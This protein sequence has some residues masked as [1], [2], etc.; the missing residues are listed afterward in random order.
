[1][2]RE[3]ARRSRCGSICVG[4]CLIESL[5]KGE[6]WACE[7]AA[8]QIQNPLFYDIYVTSKL[9]SVGL[10]SILGSAVAST[11]N[12]RQGWWQGRGRLIL[13]LSPGIY[14][15][16]ADVSVWQW[17]RW[18][19][20]GLWKQRRALWLLD[21]T[22]YFVDLGFIWFYMIYITFYHVPP[23]KLDS[24]PCW[25]MVI[26]PLIGIAVNVAIIRNS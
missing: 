4:S 10:W 15:W 5:P 3:S 20:L 7:V 25:R 9:E 23:V 2:E 19:R 21:H 18:N 1:M 14:V 22:E 13:D 6:A 24:Y 8:D 11:G 16:A 17:R 26:N 12:F